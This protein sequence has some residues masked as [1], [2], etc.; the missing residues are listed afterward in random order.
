MLPEIPTEWS[1]SS[2]T[3]GA[4]SPLATRRSQ[5]STS[6]D[7]RHGTD[8]REVLSELEARRTQQRRTLAEISESG[9]CLLS[10]QE[11]L[12]RRLQS[13]EPQEVLPQPGVSRLAALK[14]LRSQEE[15]VES[16]RLENASL[17]KE[18]EEMDRALSSRESGARDSPRF[19]VES[20]GRDY[21]SR[22]RE[23][24]ERE[25]TESRADLSREAATQE[26]DLASLKAEAYESRLQ[27]SHASGAL[28]KSI[29][30]VRLKT[31]QLKAELMTERAT[32]SQEA[33]PLQREID[34]LH[35]MIAALRREAFSEELELRKACREVA[36]ATAVEASWSYSSSAFSP[37]STTA[38]ETS[39]V[40]DSAQS[41]CSSPDRSRARLRA[42]QRHAYRPAVVP[43]ATPKCTTDSWSARFG[44]FVGDVLL[45]VDELVEGNPG[46]DS[47]LATL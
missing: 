23:L 15:V 24:L 18:L 10:Q 21:V 28:E 46:G 32:R 27:A 26:R 42:A 47:H 22:R 43:R 44:Q 13:R 3:T 16:L 19:C 8:L 14:E 2:W 45:R 6:V 11:V 30:A 29:D 12:E 25:L 37:G 9:Q 39:E 35:D 1:A 17:E 31:D 4:I 34:S 20:R 7:G 36:L 5:S 41:Q 38:T 40:W 33:Q